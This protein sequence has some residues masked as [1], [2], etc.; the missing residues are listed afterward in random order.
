MAL[1]RSDWPI[2]KAQPPYI[3]QIFRHVLL[4]LVTAGAPPQRMDELLAELLACQWAQ[5]KRKS[6]PFHI[7]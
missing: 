4:Y 7:L 3:K 6:P 1:G 2:L 5:R